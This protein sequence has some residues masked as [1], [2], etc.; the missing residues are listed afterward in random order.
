MSKLLFD[1]EGGM[2]QGAGIGIARKS[3]ATTGAAATAAALAGKAL[4]SKEKDSE[5]DDNVAV[6]AAGDLMD[7]TTASLRKAQ[8]RSNRTSGRMIRKG[9]QDVEVSLGGRLKFSEAE[10]SAEAAKQAARQEIQHREKQRN[11]SRFL[12]RKRYRDAYAAAKSGKKTAESVGGFAAANIQEA[13]AI[14][15]K[16]VKEE[17]IRKSSAILITAG[18]LGILF[19]VISASLSSCSASIQGAGSLIGTTTYPSTD[20]DIHDAENAYR[21]LEAALNAQ[22]NSVESRNANY[23]EYRYNV[24]EIWHN[25]YHLISYLT[26]KF[27]EFKYED[28]EPTI[29]ALF[30]AQYGMDLSGNTET[31]TETRTVRVGE[32]LGQVVTSGYCN[33]SICCGQWSGGPTASGV[34]PQSNHTIAVDANN[35]TVPMGTK[36]VMNGVEYVVEDTGAF[37]R[38]GVDFDVYYDSHAAASAHGHKTWEAYLADDNGSREIEV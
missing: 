12:Q 10:G 23:D 5:E 26:V 1:D 2:T 33:C 28:V 17:F 38:Y 9:Y 20:K 29:R 7:G 21:A 25:P 32:S 16:V 8:L 15:A 27:G 36:V 24:A 14:K 11:L 22:I 4:R 34:M 35:P 31:V 3:A 6:E 30:A 18:L 13:V 19:L 37:A